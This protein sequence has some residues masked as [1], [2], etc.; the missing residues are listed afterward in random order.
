MT[1]RT[2]DARALKSPVPDNGVAAEYIRDH[3]QPTDR[4]ALLLVE[5]RRG[6]AIQRI[7]SAGSLAAPDA[8][9]WLRSMNAARREVYLSVGRQLIWAKKGH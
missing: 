4:V 6:G 7:A 9:R 8:Q 1:E 5:R 3:F 2:V